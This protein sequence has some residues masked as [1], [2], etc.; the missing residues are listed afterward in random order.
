MSGS[1]LR[2][3]LPAKGW[4]VRRILRLGPSVGHEKGAFNAGYNCDGRQAEGYALTL[5]NFYACV[6]CDASERCGRAPDVI[7][8][9][10]EREKKE[11]IWGGKS[12]R[13]RNSPVCASTTQNARRHTRFR[14]EERSYQEP[15]WESVHAA[16]FTRTGVKPGRLPG[17]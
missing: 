3:R 5:V 9:P 16:G 12:I 15:K 2:P 10:S 13:A 6:D 4:G 11:M 14:R 1:I 7:P 8:R 17:G